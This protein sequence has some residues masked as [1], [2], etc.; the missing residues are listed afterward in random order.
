MHM[1]RWVGRQAAGLYLTLAYA[2]V[3]HAAATVRRIGGVD[4]M[5]LRPGRDGASFVSPVVR[6]DAAA[7]PAAPPRGR[8][9]SLV[10]GA[11]LARKR[12]LGG[13]LW[14]PCLLLGWDRDLPGQKPPTRIYTMF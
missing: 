14:L 13:T 5:Q 1:I 4:R 10:L 2:T 11:R 6:A 12:W 9:A 7:A 8:S 3:F